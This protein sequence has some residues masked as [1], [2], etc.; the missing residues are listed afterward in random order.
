[1]IKNKSNDDEDLREA[2]KAFNRDG[3]G[4]ISSV[5]L[6]QAMEAMGDKMTSLEID[7]MMA[8][9]NSSGGGMITYEDFVGQH[10]RYLFIVSL[11]YYYDCSHP[12]HNHS[13]HTCHF[14]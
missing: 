6:A 14:Y 11:N 4:S 9:I 5:E 3:S 10:S 12:N 13:P 8:A 1:M 2:F 7:D